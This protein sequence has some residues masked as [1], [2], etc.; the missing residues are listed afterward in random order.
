[1]QRIYVAPS[2]NNEVRECDKVTSTMRRRI[3]RF[4]LA[5]DEPNKHVSA[6]VP[7]LSVTQLN[8]GRQPL[9]SL[10]SFASFVLRLPSTNTLE[11]MKH[12][13]FY[14]MQKSA[15]IIFFL[16]NDVG[17]DSLSLHLS[18]FFLAFG[19]ACHCFVYFPPRFQLDCFD[20]RHVAKSFQCI[21]DTYEL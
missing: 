21:R 13:A 5:N 7:C 1:M 14:E 8:V 15:Q 6:L 11:I 12:L 17:V 3:S 20:M 4:R 19:E 2:K 10:L 9:F 18:F 16:V